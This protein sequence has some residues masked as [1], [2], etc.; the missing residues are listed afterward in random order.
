MLDRS[1][2]PEADEDAAPPPVAAPRSGCWT[3]LAALA[4]FV[5]GVLTVLV[6]L[7]A[8]NRLNPPPAALDVDDVNAA[9]AQALSVVTPPPANAADVYQSILPALVLIQADGPSA[10]GSP[11]RGVGAGVVIQTDGTLLTALH[12]VADATSIHL[13]FADGTLA[14]GTIQ[15]IQPE[16]DI[17]VVRPSQLPRVLVVAPLGNPDNVRVGDDAYVIGNPFGLYASM[18]SGV[19]SGLARDFQPSAGTPGLTGLIQIDAA[20]N[21]GTSGGPL[22]N[23]SGEVVGIIVGLANPTDQD[24]FVGIGFAVPIDIVLDPL[25]LPEF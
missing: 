8:Y 16:N 22:L 18:S 12:L 3:P 1:P 11:E 6:G 7:I 5:A 19:I 9:V 14:T 2:D 10:A 24:V 25:D 13:T 15:S 23:R 4:L 17:A 21:P 20:V